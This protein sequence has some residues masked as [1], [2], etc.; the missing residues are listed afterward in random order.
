MSIFQ[1][2]EILVIPFVSLDIV[3]KQMKVQT[4]RFDK[5]H[6]VNSTI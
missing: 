6:P 4:D 2:I 3:Q 1:P 5:I